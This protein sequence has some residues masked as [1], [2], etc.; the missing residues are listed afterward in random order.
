MS[1]SN[2]ALPDGE[3]YIDD[4][5]IGICKGI[6]FCKA[7]QQ[8]Y[9]A[10]PIRMDYQTTHVRLNI[11][12]FIPLPSMIDDA[13]VVRRTKFLLRMK[14]EK[15]QFEAV[16]YRPALIAYRDDE[17][18]YSLMDLTYIGESMDLYQIMHT[19]KSAATMLYKR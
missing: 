14:T 1:D 7:D 16:L 10:Y 5:L 3:L 6:G 2:F 19:N 4:I 17:H 15:H 13:F 8:D 12:L 11:D 9:A 18:S